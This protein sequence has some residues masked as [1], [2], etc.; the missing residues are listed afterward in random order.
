MIVWARNSTSSNLDGVR[1]EGHGGTGAVSGS[2]A[3]HP[4]GRDGISAIHE[5]EEM[6][7][8]LA[9]DLEHQPA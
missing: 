1:P 4:Q 3:R 2:G 7:R 5:L 9:V 6:V 8:T